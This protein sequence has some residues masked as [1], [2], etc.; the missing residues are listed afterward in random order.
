[1]TR[2]VM[3]RFEKFRAVGSPG[4]ACYSFYGSAH[5]AEQCCCEHDVENS[6]GPIADYSPSAPMRPFSPTPQAENGKR[7]L[8][9][10]PRR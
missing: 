3:G 9:A 7:H 8:Q 1:M 2:G 6:A 4:T 10:S 5:N